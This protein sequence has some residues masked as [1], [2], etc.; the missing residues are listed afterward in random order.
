MILP[1]NFPFVSLPV[2]YLIALGIFTL[3]HKASIIKFERYSC[4]VLN[5]AININAR[6][7]EGNS[8]RDG[9]RLFLKYLNIDIYVVTNFIRIILQE[10]CLIS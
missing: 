4:Y 2:Y 8:G 10:S 3:A 6:P 9:F 7:Y 1:R 5:N